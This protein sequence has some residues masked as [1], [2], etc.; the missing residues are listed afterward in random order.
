MLYTVLIVIGIL[1]AA[2]LAFA[3]TR[4]GTFRVERSRSIQAP[5]ERIF[6]LINDFHR[7][8][9][10]SPWEKLDPMMKR[11][12]AGAERGKGAVYAWAGNSKAGQGRMEITGSVPSSKIIIKL[13]FLKP[14]EAQ[15]T[16]EFTLDRHGS[17]TNVI[18]ATFGPQVYMAK[19]MSVFVSMDSLIGKDFEAGLAN[20]KALAESK[21]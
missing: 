7:W 14:F 16:A 3:A 20:M 6:D 2:I 4:P 1:L 18:W 11:T 12:F 15:N 5:P 21:S 13:D 8:G 17:A 9:L 19:V 10:W